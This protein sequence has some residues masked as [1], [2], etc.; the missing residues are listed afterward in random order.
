MTGPTSGPTPGATPAPILRS[1]T[2]DATAEEVAA[3]VAAIAIVEDDRRRAIALA[4][5]VASTL[6]D[7]PLD[8]WVRVS[9]LGSRRIGMQR[10]PWRIA[11]RIARRSRI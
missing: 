6:S 10:G 1:I 9:R 11:G 3:I 2:P 4:Q 5:A 8:A 7:E